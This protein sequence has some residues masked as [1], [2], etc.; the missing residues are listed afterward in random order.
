MMFK[1]YLMTGASA[2]QPAVTEASATVPAMSMAMMAIAIVCVAVMF[3]GMMIYAKKKLNASLKPFFVGC[4]V[5][6]IF[7]MILESIMHNIVL[8]S[9]VGET[10]QNNIWLYALY[11][12]FAAGVFEETGRFLAFK[13]VVK[14]SEKKLDSVVY[15]MGHGGVEALLIVGLSFIG[16]IV[17]SVLI[18][19]GMSD[20]L[21]Q[22]VTEQA[23]IESVDAQIK[24][25]TVT[26][27][28]MYLAS[29]LER[30][31]AITYHISA[32]VLV[33]AAARRGKIWL[34]P[35][36]ILIHA[37]YDGAAVVIASTGIN[38]FIVEGILAVMTV[39]IV[40]FAVKVYKGMKDGETQAQAEAVSEV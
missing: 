27:P 29:I 31:I 10:I 34:Y 25:L 4:A 8:R 30:V 12:G 7:A 26:A 33:Y 23:A 40:L 20:M 3:F 11:G 28:Y 21:Y 38:T 1:A 17:I 39:L 14:K 13:T 24:S 35:V 32:S 6:I 16:S 5:F 19:S 9:S 2:T 15:G 37:L 22:G 18:N 36:M